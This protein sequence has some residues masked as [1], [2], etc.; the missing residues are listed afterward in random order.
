MILEDDVVGDDNDVAMAFAVASRL[1]SGSVLLGFEMPAVRGK[2]FGVKVKSD[3]LGFPA[4]YEIAKECLHI[5]YGFVGVVFDRTAAGVVLNR[6]FEAPCAVDF[7]RDILSG[8]KVYH[9]R[10]FCHDDE[11]LSNLSEDRKLRVEHLGRRWHLL[12]G[13]SFKGIV[14][15]WFR[16]LRYL[17]GF[18]WAIAF[19]RIIR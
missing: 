17:F 15:S 6:L 4:T 5:A 13:H 14:A 11:V 7:Y 2:I 8:L 16:Q 18:V 10:V 3:V 9:V 12:L 19:R 1:P